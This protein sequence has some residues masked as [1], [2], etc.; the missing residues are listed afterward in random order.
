MGAIGMHV[1]NRWRKTGGGACPRDRSEDV[2]EPAAVT[3]RR[4]APFARSRRGEP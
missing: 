3:E 2:G 1:E 4:T